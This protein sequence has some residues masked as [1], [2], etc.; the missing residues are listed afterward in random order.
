MKPFATEETYLRAVDARE[1]KRQRAVLTFVVAGETYGVE[2]A[3]IREIIKI[4]DITEV[5]RVP[6]FVLGVISV[7]GLVIP[8]IDLRRRLR[9]E[10]T[11]PTRA[12][13][14][15]V[16]VRGSER[17]GL[18]IDAVREVV[19]FSDSEIEAMP[20]TMSSGESGFISG[21]GR[22]LINKRER[23]VILL[24]LDAVVKF[25]VRARGAK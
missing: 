21:I 13:R 23:M 17:F 19:R 5:P 18:L 1:E 6:R 4:I 7:R 25:D 9:L 14:I 3:D 12:A 22:T 2:I 15:L 10:A 24:H 20:S 11:P 16:V 8:V